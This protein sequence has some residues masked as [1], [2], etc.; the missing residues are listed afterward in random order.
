MFVLFSTQMRTL[1]IILFLLLC[2]NWG[3]AQTT[4]TNKNDIKQWTLQETINYALL[5]NLSIQQNEINSRLATL[6]YKQSVLAQLP[7]LNLNPTFGTSRGRSINPNSN[8]FV[9]GKYQFLSGGANSDLLLFG[10]FKQR[11]AIKKN[12]FDLEASKEDKQQLQNDVSLNVAT[13]YLRALLSKEQILIHQ[14]QVKLSTEQLHQTRE[15]AK[16]GRLPELNVAMLEA[17]LASDS[18]A[19]ITSLSDFNNA[20]I[21][22]KALINLDFETPFETIN[23]TQFDISSISIESQSPQHIF[24]VAQRNMASIKSNQFKIKSANANWKS[25][26]ASLLP[27]LHVGGQVGSNW[28]SNYQEIQGY[29][30]FTELPTGAYVSVSGTQF[31]VYQHY[32]VPIYGV[33]SLGTQLNNNFRQTYTATL[34][35]PLFN[36]WQGKYAVKQAKLNIQT[37]ILN[38]TQV[39]L[40][41]K[42]DVYKAYNDARN[43]I[44]KYIASQRSQEAAQRSYDFA[45][46]RYELGLSNTVEYL[47]TQNNLYKSDAD[48]LTSKYDLIFKL[49]IIDYYLGNPL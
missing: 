44:Y 7:S 18:A 35:I 16:V 20:I 48:F 47:T 14:K 41:L 40:K 1:F 32:N 6:N 5:H 33:P 8:Q 24:E 22:I 46:K 9:V 10:W 43:A 38:S 39:A 28:T 25:L 30:G 37:N 12:H 45:V 3:W 23:P 42:Q 11:Y 34:S 26:R 49:K 27:Q 17:Q 21:D 19:L 4:S 15:F 36:A 29:S 31:D 13:G 2:K